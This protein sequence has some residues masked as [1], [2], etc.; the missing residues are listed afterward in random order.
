MRNHTA[1]RAARPACAPWEMIRRVLHSP[2]LQPSSKVLLLCVLDHAGHGKASCTAS[3]ATLAREAGLTDR[4]AR[5]L[6]A[7]LEAYRWLESD[8]PGGK[9]GSRSFRP[10]RRAEGGSMPAGSQGGWLSI[11]RMM[12]ARGQPT[13]PITGQ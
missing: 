2:D 13:Y 12:A 6:L 9:Y 4:R 3:N 7:D 1:P 10:G 8:R 5:T 11:V